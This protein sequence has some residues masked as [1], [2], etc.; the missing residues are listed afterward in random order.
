[1]RIQAEVS[2]YPLR[3]NEL[4]KPID[5]F[6]QSLAGAGL[7]VNAGPM[8][9]RISGELR[10][11]FDAIQRAF[12]EAAERYQVVLTLKVSNACPNAGGKND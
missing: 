2:L 1:M 3:T 10:D 9:T 7:E 6:C 5:T 4:L 11:V 12:M 8:S